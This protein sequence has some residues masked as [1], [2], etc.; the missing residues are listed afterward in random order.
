MGKVFRTSVIRCQSLMHANTLIV[1]GAQ[2][3]FWIV[4]YNAV[5]CTCGKI[6]KRNGVVTL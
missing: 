2:F 1:A 4:T 6:L 3:L 5:S